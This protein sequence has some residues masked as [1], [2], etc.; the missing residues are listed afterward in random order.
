MPLSWFD[1]AAVAAER[2]TLLWWH[3]ASPCLNTGTGGR[4]TARCQGPWPGVTLGHIFRSAIHNLEL[5]GASSLLP[6]SPGLLHHTAISRMFWPALRASVEQRAGGGFNYS[7][8]VFTHYTSIYTHIYLS[9]SLPLY[10]LTSSFEASNHLKH[11]NSL[12]I[13]I[14][15]LFVPRIEYLTK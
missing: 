14:I 6:L 8:T 4:T 2:R 9:T 7:S 11:Q 3:W 5:Q 12:N 13:F 15:Y 1:I 10:H